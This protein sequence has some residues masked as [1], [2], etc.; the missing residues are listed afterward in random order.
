MRARITAAWPGARDRGAGVPGAVHAGRQ[1]RGPRRGR[2]GAGRAACSSSTSAIE[3]ELGYWGEVLTTAAQ[4]RGIAGLVID[5]GVRD[6]EALERLAVPGVQR[7][8]SRS[9]GATEGVAGRGRCAARRSVT[10]RW[11]MGDWIVG[12]RDGVTVVP[13]DATRRRARRGPGPRREGAGHVR[14][15]CAPARRRSSCSASTRPPSTALT[16]RFRRQTRAIAAGLSQNLG[17]RRRWVGCRRRGRWRPPTSRA[18]PC[19][20]ASRCDAEPMCGSSTVRGAASSRGWTSG[21]RSYTSSPAANRRPA[22]SAS[23]SAASSTTVPRAVFTSTAVGFI[24][25]RRRA[26]I[27]WRVVGAAGH[28]QR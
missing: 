20:C 7:R 23:A 11:T 24:S 3:P 2:G 21:S 17:V 15:R 27:R 26:S 28:V 18:S 1:P 19:G 4:A 8:G 5:G 25:A 9:R 13:G 10:S 16:T 12:D 14:P 6:V 22:C